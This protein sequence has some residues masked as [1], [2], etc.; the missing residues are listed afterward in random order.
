MSYHVGQINNDL[1]PTGGYGRVHAPGLEQ[2]MENQSARVANGIADGSLT[3]DEA[4]DINSQEGKY[5]RMLQ[6]F[7]ANDGKVGPRERTML[8]GQLDMTSGLIYA[9]RHDE[10]SQPT[11]GSNPPGEKENFDATITGDPHYTVN[12]SINGQAVDSAFDN[13]DVGTRTQYQGPGFGLETTTT[14]W[15]DGGASV[16][17]SATVNT[18]FGRNADAV[19]VNADGTV[20]VDGEQVSL[21]S[22]QTM[23]LNRTSSLTLNDDGTYTVSSRNGKVTNTFQAAT[24]ENGNYL[25]INSHVQDVQSWGWLENQAV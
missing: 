7:K 16:V 20:T 23:D 25:N 22:G 11:P 5:E 8:H 13:M 18:G 17:N 9:D 12:G 10:G 19:T 21:E 6:A 15:G 14:P 1:I 24:S 4:N 2:R 3:Q